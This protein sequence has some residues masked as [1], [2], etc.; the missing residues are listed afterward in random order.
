MYHYRSG[1]ACEENGSRKE[2]LNQ[3]NCYQLGRVQK[4]W[5]KS[6]RSQ[7]D[8]TRYLLLKTRKEIDRLNQMI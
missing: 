7:P 4:P 6:C 5:R 1:N 3:M 8:G 2:N